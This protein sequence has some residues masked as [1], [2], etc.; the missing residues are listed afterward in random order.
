M[1]SARSFKQSDCSTDISGAREF[2]II[3]N[4]SLAQPCRT[5]RANE[6]ALVHGYGFQVRPWQ[7]GAVFPPHNEDKYSFAS[8]HLGTRPVPLAQ[9]NGVPE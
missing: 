1:C 4:P 6:F 3:R 7:V 2:S 5:W 9:P 8:G